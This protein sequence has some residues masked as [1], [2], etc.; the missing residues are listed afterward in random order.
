M[1]K[2]STYKT[3]SQDPSAKELANYLKKN[4]PGGNYYSA[5]E[6]SFCGYSLHRA[7]EKY[8]IHSSPLK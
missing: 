2:Y 3:F 4:F 5:Y 6:A 7:L 8:G 1:L